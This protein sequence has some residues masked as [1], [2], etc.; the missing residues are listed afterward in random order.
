VL[1]IA[2]MLALLAGSRTSFAGLPTELEKALARY[3]VPESSISLFVQAVDADKPLLLHRADEPRNPASTMKL[4]TTFVALDLL[5]PAYTWPT[6]AWAAGVPAAGTLPGNLHIKG[7]GDP[8]LLNEYFWRFLRGLRQ[9]GLAHI[10]GDLVVDD[11]YFDPQAPDPAEFDGRPFR[12]YNASPDAL[13]LNYQ[14]VYFRLLPETVNRELRVV[15]DPEPEGLEINNRVQLVDGPCDGRSRSLGVSVDRNGERDRVSFSGRYPSSCGETGLYRVVSRSDDYVMGVFRSLWNEQGGSI[16]GGLRRGL[17]PQPA[18][19]LHRMESRPLADVLRGINKYSNNVMAR[20]LFL[21]LAAEQAGPPGTPEKGRKVILDW[22][23][24]HGLD[25]PGTR[26]ENGA[27]LS[28]DGRLTA[29]Q[30]GGLLTL[31][32]RHRFMPEFMSSLAL[33]A[34]D[35][36]LRKRF[37]DSGLEGRLHVKTGLLDDVRAMAG[38]LMAADGKRY[39]L[40]VLNNHP[41]IQGRRGEQVQDA[42]VN[43]LYTRKAS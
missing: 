22:L 28:R 25:A 11:S 13:L 4:V 38:Y 19:L 7:Y 12:A 3:N 42:V 34:N 35:G 36:T 17:L 15:A 37:V 5:G 21:T 1:T 16:D 20:Q 32:Y 10:R 43:W 33:S 41:G 29:R 6:E 23:A 18:Q 24:A 26:I 27:G 9:T 39:V 40:V 14:A 2:G 8:Y 31:A 30:L